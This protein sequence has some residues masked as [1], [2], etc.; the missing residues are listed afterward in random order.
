MESDS[1]VD[2]VERLFQEFDWAIPL[3]VIAT[4]VHQ[5]RQQQGRS[6]KLADLENEARR[7]LTELTEAQTAHPAVPAPRSASEFQPE[8]NVLA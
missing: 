1:Y 5:C 4:T 7:C 6:T 8:S 2:V 3:P